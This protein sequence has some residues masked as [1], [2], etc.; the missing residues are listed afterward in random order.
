MNT[1]LQ[2]A[3]LELRV[4]MVNYY[5]CKEHKSYPWQQDCFSMPHNFLDLLT[6]KDSQ[7]YFH[8][9]LFLQIVKDA[10]INQSYLTFWLLEFICQYL[11]GI[12]MHSMLKIIARQICH[13]HQYLPLIHMI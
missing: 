7:I 5:P 2:E 10:F 8:T 3:R 1:H 11:D 13:G 6:H 12:L 9:Y 4:K